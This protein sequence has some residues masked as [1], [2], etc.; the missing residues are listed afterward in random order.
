MRIN[1]M[2]NCEATFTLKSE[3]WPAKHA[4]QTK[5]EKLLEEGNCKIFSNHLGLQALFF[6]VF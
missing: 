5:K 2:R 6:R 4:K 3:N 1:A